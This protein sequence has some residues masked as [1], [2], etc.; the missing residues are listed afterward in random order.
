MGSLWDSWQNLCKESVDFLH[1]HV[2]KSTILAQCN[3]ISLICRDHQKKITDHDLFFVF[4]E[5]LKFAVPLRNTG[6]GT[7]R[8]PWVFRDASIATL[9][10]AI[11]CLNTDMK[12]SKIANDAKRPRAE[13]TPKAPKQKVNQQAKPEK[14]QVPVFEFASDG[15]WPASATPDG[16]DPRD[17]VFLDDMLYLISDAFNMEHAEIC[18]CSQLRMAKLIAIS[19][20][21]EFAFTGSLSVQGKLYK[22]WS[23]LRSKYFDACVSLVTEAKKIKSGGAEMGADDI[24]A[25]LANVLNEGT[26]DQEEDTPTWQFQIEANPSLVDCVRELIRSNK[27]DVPVGSQELYLKVLAE[28]HSPKAH[29]E[30]FSADTVLRHVFLSCRSIIPNSVVDFA[31]AGMESFE[32]NRTLHPTISD[33]FGGI[34]GVKTL[35]TCRTAFVAH[36]CL[37]YIATLG[38]AQWTPSIS[39]LH[40]FMDELVKHTDQMEKLGALEAIAS[41]SDEDMDA[42]IVKL[43]ASLDTGNAYTRLMVDG[44]ITRLIPVR[45]EAHVN[46]VKQEN[47]TPAKL[48][49]CGPAAGNAPVATHS[50]RTML[51][52]DA[53]RDPASGTL[54]SNVI[55]VQTLAL[56]LQKYL[57]SVFME[58]AIHNRLEIDVLAKKPA[59]TLKNVT[60]SDKMTFAGTVVYG[61]KPKAKP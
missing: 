22:K 36:S 49:S 26:F 25:Q 46:P 38:D 23:V 59:L 17:A 6:S 20:G 7:R 30:Q 4:F 56:E 10:V 9:N 54:F 34:T 37:S 15:T 45:P 43:T 1:P 60:A 48:P 24:G 50:N 2:C 12:N 51:F 35:A 3:T 31:T 29:P 33:I 41:M 40:S 42:H 52:S 44:M 11:A 21:L 28:V 61:E 16:L 55:H 27:W 8:V 39:A 19:L 57:F 58:D 53:L 18:S 13:T 5:A 32:T 47:A 14:Q